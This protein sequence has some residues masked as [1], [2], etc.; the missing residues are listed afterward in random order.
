MSIFADTE[1]THIWEQ[2][3]RSVPPSK[4]PVELPVGTELMDALQVLAIPEED[5]PDVLA[6]VELVRNSPELWWYVERAVWSIVAHM[7][8]IEAPPR[9]AALAD[10]NDPLHRFFYVVVYLASLPFTREYHQEIGIPDDVSRATLA[11]VGRNVRVHRKR[12][13]IGGL[14]VAWWLTIHFRGVIYQ[15][16]RLQFERSQLG[17]ALAASARSTG[18]DVRPDTPALS[19]HIPDFCGSMTPEECDAS[20]DAA[21]R[22]FPRYFPEARYDYAVC[23]S[24]LLDPR[25]KEHLKAESNIIRF[26]DRFH[27]ADALWDST[28][29]IMQFVFGKTPAD[30]DSIV[31]RTTLECAVIEHIRAGGRWYGYGGWFPL[32]SQ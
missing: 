12:E 29:G 1:Q 6:A 17:E 20:I 32:R 30:I 15:L 19:L 28:E 11:D 5:I 27:L 16:G 4:R 22:F 18:A 3:L 31:P 2:H 7:G 24:W 8:E 10:I 13:G 25:L 21:T 14:G 23:N 9:I 26:Q